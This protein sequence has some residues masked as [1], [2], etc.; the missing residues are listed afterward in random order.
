VSVILDALRRRSSD[1][2]GRADSRGS[3]RTDAVLTILGYPRRRRRG[4]LSL[5]TLL[6][7]GVASI[8][9]GFVGLWAV[10]ALVTS[11]PPAP[12]AAQVARTTPPSTQP[13]A[14]AAARPAAP[15]PTPQPVHYR[16][17]FG[18]FGGALHKSSLTFVSKAGLKGGIGEKF[19]LQKPLVAVRNTRNIGKRDMIHNSA[20]PKMSVNPETYEVRA[21]GKLLT[22]EPAK[23]LPMAQ[24][25]FL[26]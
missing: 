26:F 11:A 8:A 16:P 25:Y 1:K 12:P 6:M 15:I 9:V 7:Y 21:D 17:Q 22:C 18:A 10:L 4:R 14:Q 23:V 3:A 19:G 5:A 13:T 24:R 20:T 2:E